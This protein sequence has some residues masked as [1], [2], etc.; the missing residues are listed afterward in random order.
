MRARGGRGAQRD[1]GNPALR[2]D[3]IFLLLLTQAYSLRS[4]E[5]DGLTKALLLEEIGKENGMLR[6]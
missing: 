3:Y 2:V 6:W 1:R 5:E 4:P